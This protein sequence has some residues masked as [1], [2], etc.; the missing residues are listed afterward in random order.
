MAIGKIDDKASNHPISHGKQYIFAIGIDK[1]QHCNTLHNAV[2]DAKDMVTELTTHYQFEP[3]DVTTLYNAD[4]TRSNIYKTLDKL[5]SVVM[6]SDTLLIYFSGHGQYIDS[7]DEGYWIPVEGLNGD[8]STFVSNSD[9]AKKIKAIPALHIVVISDSCFSGALFRAERNLSV[10]LYRQEA[11]ASRWLF[12]SGRNTVVG[13]GKAGRNSPFAEG[14]LYHLENNHQAIFPIT[15]LSSLTIEA[16]GYNSEQLPRCEPMHGV[17]HKGGEFMFRLKGT[18]ATLFEVKET[19]KETPS[20]NRAIDDKKT[21]EESFFQKVIKKPVTWVTMLAVLGTSS[22]AV[23][24]AT[25]PPVEPKVETP[26]MGSTIQP[27]TPP[28]TTVTN[29]AKPAENSVVGSITKTPPA[30]KTTEKPKSVVETDVK[31]PNVTKKTDEGQITEGDAKTKKPPPPSPDG[32]DVAVKTQMC[33]VFCNTYGVA[34]V[35]IDFVVGNK[36]Y[37]KMS[38][39]N[40]SVEFEIPC[41]M[42]GSLVKVTFK[43]N[44]IVRTPFIQ[45]SGFEI[46]ADFKE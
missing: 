17:N 22:V 25:N 15:R 27:I 41:S 31:K 12:T 36:S 3:T 4:A 18:E 8:T 24:Y 42:K 45:L 16:V 13:D 46:P 37:S 26:K 39:T 6:P 20:V 43:K 7:L 9:I 35:Q 29:T 23:Y 34:G 40:S 5:V 19:P 10:G 14:L 21:I 11:I 30:S 28:I 2:K 44:G 1:Y 33:K 38:T 32:D